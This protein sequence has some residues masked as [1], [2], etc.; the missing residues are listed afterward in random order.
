VAREPAHA[1]SPQTEGRARGTDFVREHVQATLSPR[2]QDALH[3]ALTCRSHRAAANSCGMQPRDFRRSM[4]SITRKARRLLEGSG[5][6][7]GTRSS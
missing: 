5:F 2:Q 7:R 3:A 4:S 1:E 6:P